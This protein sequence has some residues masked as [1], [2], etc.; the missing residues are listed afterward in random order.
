LLGTVSTPDT[1]TIALYD[2]A[3][4]T[5]PFSVNFPDTGDDNL[6]LNQDGSLI[7]AGAEH[8]LIFYDGQLNE[9]GRFDTTK[10]F[11]SSTGTTILSHDGKSLYIPQDLQVADQGSAIASAERANPYPD[12]QRTFDLRLQP[13]G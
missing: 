9:Q 5:F 11:G 10:M 13:A 12:G 7:I 8:S 3:T 2:A 6:S 1:S 4:D